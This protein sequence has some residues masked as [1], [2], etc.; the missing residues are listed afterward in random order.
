VAGSR[1]GCVRRRLSRK[2]CW[3]GGWSRRRRWSRRVAG[4]RRGCVR[5]RLSRNRCWRGGWS[6]RKRWSRRVAGSR[7]GCVRRRLSRN[8][9]WRGGWSWRK[10]RGGAVSRSRRGGVCGGWRRRRRASRR[11]AHGE[12]R[13][14]QGYEVAVRVNTVGELDGVVARCRSR[15]ARHHERTAHQRAAGVGLARGDPKEVAQ[16]VHDIQPKRTLVGRQA[17]AVDADRLTRHTEGRR[18]HER[19]LRET[20]GHSPGQSVRAG[21]GVA[22]LQ[23]PPQF[24]FNRHATVPHMRVPSRSQAASARSSSEPG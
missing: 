20:G 10:R 23:L 18:Q 24:S 5:R 8:R 7:R 11:G 13:L 21:A 1:R 4:S 9:C 3:H 14:A 17:G 19:Q 6:R 12:A 22:V 15:R 2:R 16:A